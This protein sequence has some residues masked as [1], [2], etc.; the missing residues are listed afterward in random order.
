MMNYPNLQCPAYLDESHWLE[1]SSLERRLTR[2]YECGDQALVIGTA[3]DLIEAVAK[4]VLDTRG[5]SGG[6]NI[7]FPK[8][9]KQ[10]QEELQAVTDCELANNP[11]VQRMS[12]IAIQIEVGLWELTREVFKLRNTHG[13]GHGKVRYQ[14]LVDEYMDVALDSAVLWTRWALRRLNVLIG[15]TISALVRDLD[16]NYNFHFRKGDLADRLNDIDID[17]LDVSELRR[18]GIAVGRRAAFGTYTVREDGIEAETVTKYPEDYLWGL[19]YGSFVDKNWYICANADSID[20]LFTLLVKVL[21]I[22]DRL[23]NRVRQTYEEIQNLELSHR[24]DIET[25]QD[26]V[27]MLYELSHRYNDEALSREL[28]QIASIVQP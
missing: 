15:K 3:K 24:F 19:L 27:D 21:G 26:V 6:G 5:K 4:T 7:K 22:T 14:E 20:S 18:L 17:G 2:A 1:I 25:R 23:L 11:Y 8:L 13:S 12:E 16:A 10:A 9:I 28:A